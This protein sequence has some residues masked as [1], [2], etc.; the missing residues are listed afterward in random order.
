MRSEEVIL[1]T[2]AFASIRWVISLREL[3]DRPTVVDW[4]RPSG[5][6][7]GWARWHALVDF[8]TNAWYWRQRA[9]VMRRPAFLP[10]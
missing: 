6:V 9:E 10:R 4:A 5:A 8:Y 2:I 3:L 7:V 1:S